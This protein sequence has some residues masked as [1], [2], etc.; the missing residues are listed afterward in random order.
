V[1]YE[2]GI[3]LDLTLSSLNVGAANA[4]AKWVCANSHVHGSL[5]IYLVDGRLVARCNFVGETATVSGTPK[6]K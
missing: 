3:P 4:I 1:E 5:R 2:F 6:R